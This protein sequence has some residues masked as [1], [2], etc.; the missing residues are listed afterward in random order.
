M[1]LWLKV[2]EKFYIYTVSNVYTKYAIDLD[3]NIIVMNKWTVPVI[4]VE[5]V[6]YD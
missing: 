4:I 1:I 3:W 5:I 6:L 2:Y